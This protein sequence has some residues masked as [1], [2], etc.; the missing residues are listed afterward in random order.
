V[1]LFARNSIPNTSEQNTPIIFLK[2]EK[3]SYYSIRQNSSKILIRDIPF[4]G[5]LLTFFYVKQKKMWKIHISMYTYV[6]PKEN[7]RE[8]NY[9]S[10]VLSLRELT[11]A[12]VNYV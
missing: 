6:G 4:F 7:L 1:F 9:S 10:K 12:S 11:H 2:K 8:F 5:R 3:Y